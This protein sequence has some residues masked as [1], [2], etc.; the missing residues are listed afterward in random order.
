M[1]VCG[2]CD[3]AQD[4][5]QFPVRDMRT[6]RVHTIC[7]ACR[8]GY[9]RAYYWRNSAEYNARRR[10]RLKTVRARNRHFIQ[11]HL[12]A[13]PCVDCGLRD[14]L[15]M[16]F[17]HVRGRKRTDVSTLVRE[18]ASLAVIQAEID[19]CVVRCANCHRRRTAVTLWGKAGGA[20]DVRSFG[21]DV[22]GFDVLRVR[23]YAATAVT[24]AQLVRALDCDLRGRG[25]DP[26]QSPQRRNGS[27][28]LSSAGPFSRARPA[29]T[30][31]SPDGKAL[32]TPKL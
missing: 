9:C 4:E 15:V 26:R 8:R 11:Q 31:E 2:A 28:P 14:P 12:L 17:D 5:S 3:V 27:A 10:E 21:W 6:G 20:N 1:R 29:K 30:L 23:L 24:V 16:E 19:K 32:A 22:K 25:F 18:A 7:R 13:H